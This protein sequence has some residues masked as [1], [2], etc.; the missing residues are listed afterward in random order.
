[1]SNSIDFVPSG[2]WDEISGENTV[3]TVHPKGSGKVLFSEQS[4]PPAVDSEVGLMLTEEHN[5]LDFQ[6]LAGQKLYAKRIT[7]NCLISVTRGS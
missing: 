7:G 2:S 4:T 1:M 3:G 5:P 6:M